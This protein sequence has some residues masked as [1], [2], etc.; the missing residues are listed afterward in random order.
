MMRNALYKILGGMIVCC[1]E[2][3]ELAP[4]ESPILERGTQWKWNDIH[5]EVFYIGMN[6]HDLRDVGRFF[7]L[8]VTKSIYFLM[9]T[10]LF[11]SLRFNLANSFSSD[12]EFF[13]YF[14][15]CM[16]DTIK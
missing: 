10:N 12:T 13:S 5:A 2:N 11:V 3:P 1:T 14:F 9:L 15:K 7:V 8:I 16:L 6:H 4:P